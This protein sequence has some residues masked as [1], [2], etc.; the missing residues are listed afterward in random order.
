MHFNKIVDNSIYFTFILFLG[1]ITGCKPADSGK[2]NEENP[3]V[4]TYDDTELFFKNVRQ[5][6]YNIENQP[7]TKLKLYKLKR[8]NTKTQDRPIINLTL[9]HNWRFDE[10]YLL[11]EPN[12][13]FEDPREINI[14]WKNNKNKQ[15]GAIN[16]QKG[17]KETLLRFAYQIYQK[18]NS[19][20]EFWVEKEGKEYPFLKEKQE[21]E[22]FRVSMA[23]Y[24]RL[25][26]VNQ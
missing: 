23:D 5:I 26:G 21:R 9:I 3:S 15:K 4:K 2:F 13:F 25:V 10:A 8:Q 6:Y 24:L 7:N 12:A 1:L 19:E 17:N 18:I 16:L 20:T 14:L 22:A 11:L